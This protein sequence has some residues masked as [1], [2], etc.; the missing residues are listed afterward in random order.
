LK[1]IFLDFVS[2]SGFGIPEYD[3]SKKNATV[4]KRVNPP[5]IA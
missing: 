4:A 3:I 5:A 1:G 2:G